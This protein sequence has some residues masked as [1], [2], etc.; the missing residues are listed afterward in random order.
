M[1]SI[2]YVIPYFGHLPKNFH[3]V[4]ESM[5][6]NPTIDWL[7]FTDDKKAFDYPDN[8]RVVYCSFNEIK[9]LIQSKFD[10]DIVLNKP[11]GLC[12]FKAAY[13]EIFEDYLKDYDFWGYCDLDLMFGNL[14]DYFTDD[15]LNEYD[16]IGYQGHSTIYKNEF[17]N[18]RVYRCDVDGTVSYRE[19]F[20]TEKG[21]CFDENH[22]TDKYEKL[23]LK[24]YTKTNFAHLDKFNHGFF[25]RHLPQDESF[26]NKHQVF[27]WEKGKLTRYYLYDKNLVA[28]EEYMYIHF[29]CRPMT[30]CDAISNRYLIYADK[31]IPFTKEITHKI[32]KKYSKNNAIVF[33][34]KAVYLNRKKLSVRRI[35]KN[36]KLRKGRAK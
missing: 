23:G 9:Q 11:W 31:I 19:A 13:G 25:L 33:Y 27:L 8:V 4:L 14:R 29:W 3:L 24:Q 21:Y 1:K 17:N 12:D 6:Y 18:N 20:S 22:I 5:R 30:Y 28:Q 35:L 15:M 2:A 7:I 32:I 36:L 16:K 34:T 26:K 10:F